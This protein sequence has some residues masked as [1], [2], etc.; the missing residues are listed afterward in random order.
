MWD[1]N[2]GRMRTML[3]MIRDRYFRPVTAH[4]EGHLGHHGYC[5][6]HRAMEI[7]KYAPCTCGLLHDLKVVDYNVAIKIFPAIDEDNAK[8]DAMIPGHLY[9]NPIKTDNEFTERFFGKLVSPTEAEAAEMDRRDW[10]LIEE[11]FGEF[12]C[13]RMQLKI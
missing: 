11:V 7:Y 13:Q 10:E 2:I 12:F 5:E 9:W 4:P 8:Q 6:T 1:Y 3:T